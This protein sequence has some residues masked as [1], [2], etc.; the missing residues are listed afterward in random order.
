M[1]ELEFEIRDTGIG[2][3]REQLKNLFKPFSQGDTSTTRK[4]GGTGLGLAI[5][6]RISEAM[7]GKVW[8]T[9]IPGEGS[10]FYVRLR[11]AE[12]EEHPTPSPIPTTAAKPE[13]H[14]RDKDLMVYI[15]E[16]NKAN[17][18]VISLMLKRLGIQSEVASNGQELL[19]SIE[20]NQAADLIF[21]DLQ[22]PVMD[23][24]EATAALRQ[25][26]LGEELKSVKIVALTANAMSGDEER[27]LSAGMDG[28][29][30]KPLKIEA[31]SEEIK[32]LMA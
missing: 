15:A 23:G 2:I 30:T 26:E 14:H 1:M 4:Y 29:L 11:V 8:A 10:T 12:G 13:S 6:K 22:M 25:G 3:E 9:S 28:Y 32:R 24:L 16:D 27:C 21:M 17:Q 5:C 18:R 19:E 31:L 7:G 20:K